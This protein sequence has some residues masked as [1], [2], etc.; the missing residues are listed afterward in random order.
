[1]IDGRY[2]DPAFRI[3]VA[4]SRNSPICEACARA[5]PVAHRQFVA[6]WKK[7]KIMKFEAVASGD[8]MLSMMAALHNRRT[9]TDCGK[10]TGLFKI[11]A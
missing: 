9:W 1:L 11:D 10:V 7:A 4:F 5:E 2:I 8:E 3:N 6:R